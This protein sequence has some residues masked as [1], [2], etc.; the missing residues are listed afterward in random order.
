MIFGN[1]DHLGGD[2]TPIEWPDNVHIFSAE[3]IE[4]K[5]F[6]KDGRLAASIYGYS[7]PERSVYAN[8][9]AEIKND[10]RALAYRHDSWNAFRESGHDPYC[11]FSLQ[12]LKTDRWII[13]RLDI[14]IKDRSFQPPI[15]R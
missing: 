6:Y 12:D 9:A 7:Y 8:K 1:H 4:E 14:Y 15:R 2:W 3:D 13:G 10:R 11:P 5:S